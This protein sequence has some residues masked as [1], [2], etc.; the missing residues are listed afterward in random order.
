MTMEMQAAC[1]NGNQGRRTTSRRPR[2]VPGR[3]L[4]DGDDGVRQRLGVNSGRE[5]GY[6]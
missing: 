6:S 3:V 1:E 5:V 2:R 4:V